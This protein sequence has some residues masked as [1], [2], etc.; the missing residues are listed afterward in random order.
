MTIPPNHLTLF[1]VLE[2]LFSSYKTDSERWEGFDDMSYEVFKF[3]IRDMYYLLSDIL[4]DF[5]VKDDEELME[6]SSVQ[7][8]LNK[9]KNSSN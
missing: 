4:V 8:Y 6:L 2:S 7:F 9:S 3:H 5:D 1:C